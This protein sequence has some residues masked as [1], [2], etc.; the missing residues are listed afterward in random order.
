MITIN[1]RLNIFGYPGVP[2]GSQNL[3]LQDQRLAIEWIR[4]NVASFSGDPTK[5]TIFGQSSG[6]LAADFWSYAYKQ[7]PIVAGIVSHSG[8]AYS[9]PLN[10]LALAEQN[11]YNASAQVGCGSSGDNLECMR[12]V[13]WTLIRAAAAKVP[14]PPGTS[15]ARSQPPF[16]ATIDEIRVFSNYYARAE[17]G[18]H[19]RIVSFPFRCILSVVTDLRSSRTWL[20]TIT[21][22]LVTTK[23]LHS[24]KAES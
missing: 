6:G 13:D 2:G 21:M 9:F 4:D 14:A 11:W 17:A 20:V 12:K 1:F 23:S 15:Q 3:G 22:K 10:T 5:I 24:V 19:A 7:D 16:Q 8:N 18:N